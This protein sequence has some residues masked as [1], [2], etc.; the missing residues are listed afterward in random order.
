MHLNT[1]KK[2][3]YE[4][5]KTFYIC[6]TKRIIDIILSL[7]AMAVLFPLLL[8]TAVCILIFLGRP[9]ILHQERT[10]LCELPFTLFKFR[11]MSNATDDYGALLPDEDRL[12][13]LGRF[14]RA[15]SID[16]LPSLVNV[17]RGDISIVGPR[18][19]LTRYIPYYRTDE[20]RRHTVKPGLTGLAQINGR[21]HVTWEDKFKMDLEYVD[22]CALLIDLIIMLRT[23]GALFKFGNV[24]TGSSFTYD[25]VLYRPLDIERSVENNRCATKPKAGY[26][27]TA[28]S[29]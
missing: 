28:G 16:E 5:K 24:Q 19:L 6:Y 8:I 22:K 11:T 2:F 18:P 14:L 9:I 3:R 23:L 10:G 26:Q 29:I 27:P 25:Q 17:L 7:M 4:L 15:S 13:R 1:E 21:N 12:Q 20:H